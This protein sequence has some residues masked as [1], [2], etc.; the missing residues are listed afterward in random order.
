[1]AVITVGM[2]EAKTTLSQ[3]VKKA[4][5]G[6]EVIISSNGKPVA[7]L[8]PYSPTR[9]ERKPGMLAG[10]IIIKPGF[11]DLPDGFDVLMR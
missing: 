3:L 4:A 8:V 10:R 5:E 2:H 7:K 6:Q 11:D 1:M 9:T